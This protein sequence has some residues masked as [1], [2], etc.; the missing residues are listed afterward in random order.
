MATAPPE[1]ARAVPAR[2]LASF[3][4]QLIDG[5]AGA[6]RPSRQRRTREA[7]ERYAAGA[8]V[9]ATQKPLARAGEGS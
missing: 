8:R 3:L 4:V 6:L 1:P 9:G 2:P 7:S 5:P